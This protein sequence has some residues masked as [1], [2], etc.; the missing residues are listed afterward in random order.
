MAAISE[1][2]RINHVDHMS[3]EIYMHSIHCHETH[4]LLIVETGMSTVITELQ[5]Q[6]D[7]WIA[8]NPDW[9]PLEKELTGK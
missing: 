6:L 5:R 4:E 9:N 7:A 2:I 3:A 1:D 8:E